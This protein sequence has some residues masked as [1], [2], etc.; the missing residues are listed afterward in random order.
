MGDWFSVGGPPGGFYNPSDP[1]T[2]WGMPLGWLHTTNLNY[3]GYAN[4]DGR[5][6][7]FIGFHNTDGP[8]LRYA[9]PVFG[10]QQAGYNFLLNFY[11]SALH[12]RNPLNR[13]LDS[14]CHAVWNIPSFEGSPYDGYRY[15]E[16]QYQMVLYGDGNLVLP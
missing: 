6:Y 1:T 3:N 14:A 15:P 7:A 2:E 5:G 13:A 9:D 10:V 12:Y 16:R 11:S 4:P 8:Q